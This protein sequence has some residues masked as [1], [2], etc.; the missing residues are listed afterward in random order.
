MSRTVVI[1]S[2]F[3]TANNPADFNFVEFKI[4]PFLAFSSIST[5]KV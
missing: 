4:Y 2:E 5:G 3:M 1:H